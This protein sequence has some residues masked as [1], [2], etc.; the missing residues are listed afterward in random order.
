MKPLGTNFCEIVFRNQTFSFKKMHLKLSS[1]KWQP[2]VSASMS[3]GATDIRGFV[4]YLL[5]KEI[6]SIN[7]YRAIGCKIIAN[8]L[9]IKNDKTT[10][11]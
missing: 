9:S 6:R 3:Y 7:M 5:S 11:V 10:F 8:M 4:V 1:A 2:F